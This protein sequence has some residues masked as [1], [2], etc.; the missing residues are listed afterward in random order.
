MTP[1]GKELIIRTLSDNIIDVNK[2]KI[3]KYDRRG[4]INCYLQAKER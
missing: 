1:M 3:N 4:C 2:G